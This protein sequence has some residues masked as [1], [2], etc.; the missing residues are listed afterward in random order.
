M[1]QKE[2]RKEGVRW[3]EG[4]KKFKGKHKKTGQWVYGYY[5]FCRGHHY[6]LQDYNDNGY[7]ERWETSEWLEV[8]PESVNLISELEVEK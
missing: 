3:L 8:L 2:L 6:I 7:D 5:V 1:N 4:K